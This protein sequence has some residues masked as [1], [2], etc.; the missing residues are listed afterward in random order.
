MKPKR[1]FFGTLESPRGIAAFLVVIAHMAG[2]GRGVLQDSTFVANGVMM[3]PFFFV[4]SGFV[5]TYN[6][7]KYVDDITQFFRFM[8]LRFFRLYPV[9]FVFLMV[10]LGFE[11][12]RYFYVQST[13]THPPGTI[14]FRENNLQALIENLLLVQALGSRTMP[15]PSTDPPGA[16]V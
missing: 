13:G 15:H 5:I 14:P 7:Y 12:A 16:L 3:V 9:H 2:G 6:Y 4:L 11:I 8:F 1:F 10:W